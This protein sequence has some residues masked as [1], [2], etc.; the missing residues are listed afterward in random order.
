MSSA[1]IFVW[2]LRVNEMSFIIHENGYHCEMLME[3]TT[4]IAKNNHL[5]RDDKLFFTSYI[6][7]ITNKQRKSR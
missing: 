4:L 2:R 6:Q 5:K 1:A 7:G 3:P